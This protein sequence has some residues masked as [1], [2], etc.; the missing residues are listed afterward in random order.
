MESLGKISARFEK[1]CFAI[2]KRIEYALKIYSS[3]DVISKSII[4]FCVIKLHDQWNA[5]CRELILKSA[6][7]NYKTLSG[8][9][10]PRSATINP[11]QQLR[12]TWSTRKSMEVSWE[13]DWHVPNVSVRA[14]QLLRIANY[15]E[16]SNAISALTII[17]DLRWTRNAI[18]HEL[19]LTYQMFHNN[20]SA[21]FGPPRYSPSDYAIQRIPRTP[22][23]IIIDNWITE[24]KLA[25]RAAVR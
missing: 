1:I 9:I 10:L 23:I 19:P 4:S 7:G 14:A 21:R 25:L 16:V 5:R 22:N 20:Q 17:D 18:A 2:D 24:L 6:M 3:N 8:R 13:P 15:N 11:L 12:K